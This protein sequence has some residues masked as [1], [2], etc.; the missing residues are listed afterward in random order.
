M[1]GRS[2]SAAD[3]EEGF[4]TKRSTINASGLPGRE[5]GDEQSHNVARAEGEFRLS[6]RAD[7]QHRVPFKSKL[8]SIT[9]MACRR[10]R[11]QLDWQRGQA[12]ITPCG[13]SCSRPT[14]SVELS[15]F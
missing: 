12:L 10:V 6:E 14:S 9:E 8:S 11:R 13:P 7:I 4:V 1:R 5:K 2:E 3:V 15:A